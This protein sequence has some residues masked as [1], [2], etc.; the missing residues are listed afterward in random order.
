M[1]FFNIILYKPLFNFLVFI[2]NIIPGNDFGIAIIVLTIIIKTI[3]V[4]FSVKA[5]RSQKKLQEVQPKIKEIQEKYKDNKEKQGL[6]LLQIYKKEKINPFGS[7]IL[8]F[9]QLPILIALYY[10]FRNGLNSSELTNLYGFLQNPGELKT[11]FLGIINLAQPNIPL[12]IL[13]ALC[14]F[15]QSK[16]LLPKMENNDNSKGAQITKM[17]QMQTMY[18]MPVMTFLILFKLP[19]AL[20]LYWIVSGL[21]SVVQQYFILKN[22]QN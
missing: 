21:F 22:K 7:I 1:D 13:A 2:Y 5:V 16:M 9:I 15:F 3:L 8:L 20:G 4:P 10:V 18:F 14:Q 17:M 19:S 11:I 6:E 12:A